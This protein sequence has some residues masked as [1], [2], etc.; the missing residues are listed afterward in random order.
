MN[1]RKRDICIVI[2][3]INTLFDVGEHHTSTSEAP[4]AGIN[5]LITGPLS[6]D[7]LTANHLAA[8]VSEP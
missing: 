5:P 4:E 2:E 1:K 6:H 3:S 7:P 8:E